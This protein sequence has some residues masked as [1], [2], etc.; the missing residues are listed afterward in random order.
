V[1]A[2]GRPRPLPTPRSQAAAALTHLHAPSTPSDPAGALYAVLRYV[3]WLQ[4][5]LAGATNA[6][7]RAMAAFGSLERIVELHDRQAGCP[8]LRVLR[9]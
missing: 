7:A 3:G 4:A 9:G 6:Y 1:R 8:G 5:G 2:I